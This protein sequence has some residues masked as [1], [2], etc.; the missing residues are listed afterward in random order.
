V[1]GAIEVVIFEE[2][3]HHEYAPRDLVRPSP[4]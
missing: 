4:I 2:W 3:A 1:L